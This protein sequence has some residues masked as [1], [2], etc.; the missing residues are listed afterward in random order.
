M[1]IFK[2]VTLFLLVLITFNC[3]DSNDDSNDSGFN[4]SDYVYF[5]SGKIDGVPFF[6]GQLESATTLDYN[7]IHSGASSVPCAFSDGAGISYFSGVYPNFDNDTEPSMGMEFVRFMLCS[8]FQDTSQAEGFNDRFPIGNYDVATSN[9]Y[10]NGT[11]GAIAFQY[12]ANASE[13]PFYNTNGDQ[14]GNMV[15]ITSTTPLNGFIL[16]VQV[17]TAQ[18]IEGAFSATLYN[19]EDSSDTVQITEGQFRLRPSL[20]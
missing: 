15:N 14:T 10:N 5:M 20:Q 18:F 17:T 16:D 9:D 11:T 6:Y 3:S 8:E 4:A 12:A 13:G 19:G 1:K 7:L 2:N